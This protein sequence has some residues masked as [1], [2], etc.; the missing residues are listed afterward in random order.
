LNAVEVW[1][2]RL[3]RRALR[4]GWFTSAAQ[5]KEAIEHFIE[6]HNQ[7]SARPFQ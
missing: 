6:A 3:E 2:S 1:L 7:Y 4:R 5:L